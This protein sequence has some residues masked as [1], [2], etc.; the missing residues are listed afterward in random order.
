MGK[1]IE[2]QCTEAQKRRLIQAW[3]GPDGCFWPWAQKYCFL[4]PK[5]NCANCYE[6]RIKWNIVKHGG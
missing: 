3:R 4:D 6:K 1:K 2:I 5:A